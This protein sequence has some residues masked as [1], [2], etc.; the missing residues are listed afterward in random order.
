MSDEIVDDFLAHYGV[1]GMKW[2][3]RRARN[4]RKAA[5]KTTPRPS[6]EGKAAAK[7]LDKQKKYGTAAL[8]N[9]EL[10]MLNARQKLEQ[11]FK[12][13]NPD[14]PGKLAKI[15]KGKKHAELILGT[16]ETGVKVANLLQD[17]KVRK[18]VG[19]GEKVA[20]ATAKP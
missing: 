4:N 19:V 3:I 17:P 6:D 15:E 5:L 7:V 1:R 13:N 11:E 2:G 16:I 14:P 18:L 20:T 8:T 10:R 9:H 12:K